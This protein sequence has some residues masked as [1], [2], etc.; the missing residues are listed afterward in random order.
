MAKKN[1]LSSVPFPDEIGHD[2]G[3]ER[4]ILAGHPIIEWEE[5]PQDDD[6][7]D[8]YEVVP[9]KSE[10]EGFRERTQN[11][12][13]GYRKISDL[14]DTAKEKLD[15]KVAA[16][17]GLDVQLDQNRDAHTIAANKRQF[18]DK[19]PNVITYE[20]YRKALDFIAKNQDGKVPGISEDDVNAAKTDPL[21]TNFGGVGSVPGNNRPEI[22][23]PANSVSP[24]DLKVFQAVGV[25]ALFKL[26]RPYIKMEDKKEIMEHLLTKHPTG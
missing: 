10:L 3:R 7:S 18:P 24:I 20:M 14:I 5:P 22:S 16:A 17:G 9:E 13:D 15:R 23:S 1:I 26:L 2:F 12:V 19:N 25:V 8:D 6:L 21:R 11:I 4:D